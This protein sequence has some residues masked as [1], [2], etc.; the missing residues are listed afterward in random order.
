MRYCVNMNSMT[1]D[2]RADLRAILARRRIKQTD[3]ARELGTSR[4]YLS[5]LLN[6]QRGQLS[7][8]WE[9]L[10]DHLDLDL[11]VRPRDH[12]STD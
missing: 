7:P 4:T 12:Q 9:K 8:V 6:G 1:D 2:I 5:N 3:L 11:V 10:L